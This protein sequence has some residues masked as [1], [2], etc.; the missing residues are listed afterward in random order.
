MLV[1]IDKIQVNDRIRRDY[2]DLEELADNIRE[3]TLM[4]PPVVMP[5]GDGTY[6]LIAGERRLRA[7]RDV[8]G[9][10]QTEVNVVTPRDAEQM[11]LM[12]ISENE[13]R[14]EFTMTERLDYAAKIKAIESAKAKERQG[15]RTDLAQDFVQSERNQAANAVADA[16]GT[17]RETLRQAQIISN[18]R[19]LLDPAE[20]ADWDEGKLSTNKAFQKIK[21]AQKQAEEAKMQAERERD[22][23]KKE[24]DAAL[25]ERSD[26]YCERDRLLKEV[27]ALA[28][29][30]ST[31]P[32][33]E[34]VERVV[35]RE[36]AP[37]DYDD[38]KSRL[39]SVRK[40]NERLAREYHDMWHA[41]MEVDRQLEQA[42]EEL[43]ERAKDNGANRDVEA[44]V[45]AIY[46][47]L[48]RHGGKSRAFDQFY[49]VDETTQQECRKA[50]AA[51]GGFAQCLLQMT[52]NKDALGG[53]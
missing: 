47:L 20:F 26:A 18:N 10:R 41:K 35:E 9:Y 43:G 3:N 22:E 23:A 16:I 42:N 28:D 48:D 15:T 14:K 25:R 1:E 49:R 12:E 2:G 21:A 40:D 32:E 39:A 27:D 6:T 30:L 11:L 33:P 37:A 51:L 52:D 29:Q 7:M 44:L 45:R 36:V 38:L 46:A 13:C 8:L 50:L 31:R 17:N 24:R 34:V 5:N 19:D 53:A 4:N